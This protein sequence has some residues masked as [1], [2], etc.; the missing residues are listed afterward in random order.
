MAASQ[1]SA[2]TP[3]PGQHCRSTVAPQRGGRADGPVSLGAAQL[4]DGGRI[5]DADG[6]V[7]GL[8]GVDEPVPR[9]T[10]G[11][12]EQPATRR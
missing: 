9:L 3:Q 7:E 2:P 11:R 1:N 5:E 10:L 4:G 6:V 8:I 12:G